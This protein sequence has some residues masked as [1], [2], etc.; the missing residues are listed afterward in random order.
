MK[1]IGIDVG[2]GLSH[3]AVL[4]VAAE[5]GTHV[6]G[7]AAE[8]VEYGA[9]VTPYYLPVDL[10]PLAHYL[11]GVRSQVVAVEVARGSVASGRDADP[12]LQVNAVAGKLLGTLQNCPDVV[13]FPVASGGDAAGWNWRSALGITGVGASARDASVAQL[14]GGALT[15]PLPTGPRGGK[16]S[17]YADAA[18]LAL[19]VLYRAL[20]RGLSAKHSAADT[21]TLLSSP[22]AVER[23]RLASKQTIKQANKR[24]RQY[25]GSPS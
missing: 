11:S 14:V 25:T 19:A 13:A 6:R 1:I 21:L 18:G 5:P 9:L 15:S 7:P 2:I 20:A 8:L 16:I 24:R 10:T 12:I 17:H 4:Q 22:D 3:F 23:H